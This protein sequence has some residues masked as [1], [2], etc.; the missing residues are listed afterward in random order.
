MKQKGPYILII[1][2][3]KQSTKLLKVCLGAHGYT[4]ENTSDARAGMLLALNSKPDLLILDLDLS[5]MDGKDVI[6]EIRHVLQMPIV[7]LTARN[8]VKETVAAL[9]AG[10]DEYI[11]KPFSS[12]EILARIRAL[13]RRFIVADNRPV[14]HCDNLTIDLVQRHV[15]IGEKE[16]QLTP[17]EYSIISLL[18]QHV[19]KVITHC[20]LYKAIRDGEPLDAHYLR[21]YIS[22]LR[23]KL[24][25]DPAKPR[26]IIT[27]PGVGYR[28]WE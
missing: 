23:Y 5:D 22:K 4:V 19:G 17:T 14:I 18:A 15:M 10:A 25:N 1:D 26:Y 24:E 6:L 7:V 8:D 27:E 13:L 21:V 20:Q 9:D 2:N 3:D 16:I 12:E 11:T 28:L